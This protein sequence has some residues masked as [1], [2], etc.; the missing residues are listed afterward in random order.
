MV[1][2]TF[3]L[4]A[5][6]Y[7]PFHLSRLAPGAAFLMDMTLE[8]IAEILEAALQR[9]GC[10]RRQGAEGMSGTQEARMGF[11]QFK[12]GSPAAALLHVLQYLFDPG[13]P[14]PARGAPAARFLRLE[15]LQIE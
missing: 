1:V 11:Q 6:L 12:V 7:F 2:I 13:K 5:S 3:A 8:I 10:A 9:L 14:R 4:L 15:M